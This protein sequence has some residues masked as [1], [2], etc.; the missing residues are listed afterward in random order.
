MTRR[1][2]LFDMDRTLVDV[3]TARLYLRLQ[4]ELGEV[5]LLEALRGSYWLLQYGFGWIQAES[6]ALRLLADYRGR[7]EEWL[8][9]RCRQWFQSHVRVWVS[10]VGRA[11]VL[12]HQAAGHAVA[13]A[14]SA[15]RQAALPLAEELAI[16]HL[17]CSELEVE[18]CALTGTFERP[19]CYGSGKL[20]RA[21]S[22]VQSLGSSLEQA[23]FYTDSITDLP[24]LEAVGQPVAVNPDP[25]LRRLARRRGWPIEEW[26][27]ARRA[28]AVT[29]P[30]A[31]PAP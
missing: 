4:R 13:I 28:A 19:L 21:R 31:A 7:P 24:L 27:S 14:T 9:E 26:R 15:V 5:G 10:S 2:A 25:R 3:H 30:K 11:R 29:D 8:R 22:L 12:E 17:V 23:I 18:S 1:V 16:E 6:V 20:E